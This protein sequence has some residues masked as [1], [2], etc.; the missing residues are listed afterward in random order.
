VTVEGILAYLGTL[1]AKWWLPDRVFFDRVPFTATGKIDKR[2]LRQRYVN[3][4]AAQ[5]PQ[6]AQ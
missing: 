2:A 4:P 6:V 3:L 1:V 5:C